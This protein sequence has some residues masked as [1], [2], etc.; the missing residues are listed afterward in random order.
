[1]VLIF[2][3]NERLKCGGFS[4]LDLLTLSSRKFSR[5]FSVLALTVERV[6]M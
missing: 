5:P 4:A 1:M 2:K 6:L 3:V